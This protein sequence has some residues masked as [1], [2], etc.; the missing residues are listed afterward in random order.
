MPCRSICLAYKRLV[1]S[2]VD[3]LL[4]TITVKQEKYVSY[5]GTVYAHWF[6]ISVLAAS[7]VK[8]LGG[9]E[10]APKISD[11][12]S[13][14]FSIVSGN[15]NVIPKFL[16]NAGFSPEFCI[17]DKDFPTRRK[18]SDSPK[19]RGGGQLPSNPLNPP[20]PATK[21]LSIITRWCGQLPCNSNNSSSNSSSSEWRDNQSLTYDDD[22]SRELAASDKPPASILQ[23][24]SELEM[25]R[26]RLFVPNPSHFNEFILISISIWNLNPIPIF[27][28][29]NPLFH[30]IFLFTFS[31]STETSEYLWR[32]FLCIRHA[33]ADG[34]GLA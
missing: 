31:N 1:Q 16:K 10:I 23:V 19:F 27:P 29:S 2:W 4:R 18:F 9:Q 7:G 17:L 5:A 34:G 13:C 12:Q 11:R 21:P 6:T 3:E 22:W 32:I 30:P 33:C 26:N 8:K 24:D 14:E 25:C 20:P 15:F 28:S